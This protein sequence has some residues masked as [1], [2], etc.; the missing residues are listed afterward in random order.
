MRKWLLCL[1]FLLF[2]VLVHVATLDV[3]LSLQ[4][5][6]TTSKESLT[7]LH[8]NKS[9]KRGFIEFFFS[10]MENISKAIF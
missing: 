2:D 8:M 4:Q 3:P 5:V 1:M 9:T 7:G 6:R 10:G